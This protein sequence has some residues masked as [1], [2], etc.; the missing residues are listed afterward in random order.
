MAICG[1]PPSGALAEAPPVAA[2]EHGDGSDD[3][4]GR[5]RNQRVEILIDACK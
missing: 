4:E 3:P 5:Q 2:N 1:T